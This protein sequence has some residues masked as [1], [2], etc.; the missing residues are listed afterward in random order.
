M[1]GMSDDDAL[2]CFATGAISG[3]LLAMAIMWVGKVVAAYLLAPRRPL[4]LLERE[5][6]EGSV[7]KGGQNPVPSELLL[8]PPVPGGSCP[9]GRA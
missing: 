7:K 4:T 9:R 2:R 5:L 8:R 6:T 1:V 3:V